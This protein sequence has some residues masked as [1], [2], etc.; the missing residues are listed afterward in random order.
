MSE[1]R[2]MVLSTLEEI[3]KSIKMILSRFS[4]IK[5]PDGFLADEAAIEKPDSISMRLLA[6]G[7]G[8]KNIDKLT[9]RQLLK[10]YPSIE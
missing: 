5:T 10:K 6:I 3:E 2:L 4:A 9:D 1:S 7:E 8:F